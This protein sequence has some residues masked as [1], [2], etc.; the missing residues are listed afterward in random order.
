MRC[1]SGICVPGSES[2]LMKRYRFVVFILSFL[3]VV[4]LTVLGGGCAGPVN[5]YATDYSEFESVWQ[6]LKVYSIYQDRVPEDPFAF[7][8]PQDIMLAVADT[9]YGNDLAHHY[10]R[11]AFVSGHSAAQI[12]SSATVALAGEIVTFDSL[13]DS[14]AVIRITSFD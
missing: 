13:T 8:T 7:K 1:R 12:S 10:T 6:Y 3:P 14:T 11:Y 4:V 5:E 9:L 2:E